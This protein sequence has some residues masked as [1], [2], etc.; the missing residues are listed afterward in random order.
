MRSGSHGLH[1]MASRLLFLEPLGRGR[2]RRRLSQ[3]L[4]V[5]WLGVFAGSM[6]HSGLLKEYKS[7]KGMNHATLI[8]L[9][10]P[11]F[12]NAMNVLR[13]PEYACLV[14]SS[15][16]FSTQTEDEMN[17]AKA[18]R[19]E[20]FAYA[21][22]LFH[23][24]DC[25]DFIA[26]TLTA[27]LPPPPPPPPNET[28][29]GKR[30]MDEPSTS[31]DPPRPKKKRSMVVEVEDDEDE[32]SVVDVSSGSESSDGVGEIIEA[33]LGNTVTTP[34]NIFTVHQA[35][36]AYL[37]MTSMYSEADLLGVTEWHCARDERKRVEAFKSRFSRESFAEFD[38]RIWK[39]Y[40]ANAQDDNIYNWK[41]SVRMSLL[42]VTRKVFPGFSV[43][44]F[45]VGSTI[46]GCGSYNSDM[47][48]CLVLYN[49]D[50]TISEGQEFAKRNLNK[51]FAEL[52]KSRNIV[53]KCQFI[54]HAVV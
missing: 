5:I 35:S 41:M 31:N 46:N 22:T 33:T 36:N 54:R 42:E 17:W 32:C 51:V 2:R 40:T 28:K 53:A 43:N 47:D 10:K 8:G 50:G 9:S 25:G 37:A 45:A 1:S 49:R 44:M 38:D 29:N 23:K 18:A 48:L 14:D 24:Y 15:R 34:E 6:L 12:D 7:S 16:V 30:P 39:H 19:K 11:I 21:K 13:R 52:K 26:A 3:W 20:I 27:L 4:V